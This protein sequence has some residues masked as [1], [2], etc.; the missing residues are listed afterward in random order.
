MAFKSRESFLHKAAKEQLFKW[1]KDAEH[2]SPDKDG[3][4]FAQFGWRKNYGVFMELPFHE[5][6][7]TCYFERSAF[8]SYDH[9]NKFVPLDIDR[10]KILFVPDIAVFHKGEPTMLFEIVVTNPVT[11][12]KIETIKRFYGGSHVE[13][14]EVLA[15]DIMRLTD[16]PNRL[17]CKQII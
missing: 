12:Y 9:N 7:D 2:E 14:Y 16:K 3:C 10:G 15:M 5:T 17:P 6:D 13:V 11:E 8:A 4:S 1:L